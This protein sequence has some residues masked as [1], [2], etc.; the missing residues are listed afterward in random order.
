[1]HC[2]FF[3]RSLQRN[4]KIF[5]HIYFLISDTKSCDEP[6]GT[7]DL[8]YGNRSYLQQE[9]ECPSI[10]GAMQQDEINLLYAR[11]ILKE[12]EECSI[13]TD[14]EEI[15]SLKSHDSNCEAVKM[16]R[17]KKQLEDL[18]SGQSREN[19]AKLAKNG[20]HQAQVH[21]TVDDLIAKEDA[22]FTV[23][24]SAI[25]PNRKESKGSMNG[26][27]KGSKGSL[28]GSIT[29]EREESSSSLFNKIGEGSNEHFLEPPNGF[30]SGTDQRQKI[31]T[32]R[33]KT[34]SKIAKSKRYY[35]SLSNQGLERR[36]SG[37]SLKKKNEAPTQ[38][39]VPTEEK[40]SWGF[41]ED[42][43]VE[44]VTYS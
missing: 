7:T 31:E 18:S 41:D 27:R 11:K 10:G 40:P 16:T 38:A 15:A 34:L 36:N 6:I 37:D 29:G 17:R 3:D 12:L 13:E 22:S 2:Y 19:L 28:V 43:N 33:L 4:A 39:G 44:E 24:D 14:P 23:M 9:E 30:Q 32:K 5:L 8:N 35:E 26:D 1:M 25:E 21:T 42:E 20:I